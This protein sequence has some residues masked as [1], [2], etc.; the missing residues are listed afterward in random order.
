MLSETAVA[1]QPR[2]KQASVEKDLEIPGDKLEKRDQIKWA[3]ERI[4]IGGMG[5]R[6]PESS[7]IVLSWGKGASAILDDR[8]DRKIARYCGEAAKRQTEALKRKLMDCVAEI[9][10]LKRFLDSKQID[11]D[12]YDNQRKAAWS[13][14]ETAKHLLQEVLNPGWAMVEVYEFML[15]SAENRSGVFCDI[16]L[17]DTR[18]NQTVFKVVFSSVDGKTSGNSFAYKIT[19]TVDCLVKSGMFS[20]RPSR[21]YFSAEIDYK[22]RDIF[23][24]RWEPD[25]QLNVQE[26]RARPLALPN[27]L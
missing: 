8:V 27:F 2:P 4:S 11:E 9:D 1:V 10:R 12:D 7:T 13:K 19:G 5:P 22:T 26:Y 25:E 17:V 18:T 24:F 14:Y 21:K 23:S 16:I 20:K 3:K 15:K 6:S